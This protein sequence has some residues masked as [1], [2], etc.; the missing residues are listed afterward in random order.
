MEKLTLIYFEGCPNYLPA[1]E[2]L[3]PLNV[4]FES[5]NQDMLEED[6]PLK[7]YSSPTLLK[8][9][10]IIFGSLASGGGCSLKLPNADELLQLLN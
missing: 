8:G 9:S 7:N 3:E 4:K 6:N 2:L 1:V 10:K 5:V